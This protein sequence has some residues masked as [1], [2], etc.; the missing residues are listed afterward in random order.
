MHAVLEETPDRHQWTFQDLRVTQLLVDPG[1]FRIQA[2]HLSAQIEL[3]LGVPFAFRDLDGRSRVVD[4]EAPEQVAPLLTLVGRSVDAAMISR[5]GALAIRFG[6]G[7]T[8]DI[9]P[10]D[11]FEAWE[12][13]GTGEL[14]EV[15]YLCGVGGGSPWG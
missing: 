4:P 8:I 11:Q 12:I 14:A 2:W 15:N 13:Q 3:R 7:S 6:D 9:E 1:S 5:S 10:H